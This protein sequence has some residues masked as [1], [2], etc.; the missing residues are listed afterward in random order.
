VAQPGANRV[1]PASYLQ[2]LY[3]L[4]SRMGSVSPAEP[5][6]TAVGRDINCTLS[7]GSVT[8]PQAEILQAAFR[9]LDYCRQGYTRKK[10]LL[11]GGL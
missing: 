1:R 6:V 8:E 11:Q 2:P 3:I 4:P 5:A 7:S 9:E 10:C